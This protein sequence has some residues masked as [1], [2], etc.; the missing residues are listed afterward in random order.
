MTTAYEESRKE[1]VAL[2]AGI[3]EATDE[4]LRLLNVMKATIW[5]SWRNTMEDK[6][7]NA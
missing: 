4:I 5:E 2:L 3:S 1:I 7:T 6:D